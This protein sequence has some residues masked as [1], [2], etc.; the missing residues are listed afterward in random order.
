MPRV[1]EIVLPFRARPYQKRFIRAMEGGTKYAILNYHRQS[2]KDLGFTGGWL[3]PEALRTIG[4]YW[5]CFPGTKE[6][7][8]D[9]WTKVDNYGNPML[10]YYI[11]YDLM[12]GGKPH[13]TNH[14]FR[15]LNPYHPSKPGSLISLIAMDT[16]DPE[17]FRGP[18]LKGV[19]YSEYSRYKSGRAFANLQP[20]IR[21][22]ENDGWQAIMTTPYG[23]NHYYDM[24]QINKDN[25]DWFVQ[26]LTIED[27]GVWGNPETFIA[28][29]LRRGEAW[30]HLQQ[31]YY[32][33]FNAYIR[34]VPFAEE[35]EYLTKEGRLTSVPWDPMK[36]VHTAWDVG[37]DG[38][39]IWFIQTHGLGYKFIDFMFDEKINFEYYAEQIRRKPYVYGTHLAPFDL[40]QY[41][42]FAGVTK[43]ESARELGIDFTVQEKYKK[44]DSIA[45]AKRLLRQSWF[46]AERCKDGLHAMRE[47]HYKW[48]GERRVLSKD[49]VHD[50]SS[51]AC[52]ALMVA[53]VGGGDLDDG[54]A[55][56]YDRYEDAQG[57]QYDYEFDVF[58]A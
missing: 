38:T 31:E 8:R 10:G 35:Y 47:Y 6:I 12:W 39:A 7:R 46:D 56:L 21:A 20:A 19:G 32:C 43:I 48:D 18:T 26:T 24:F 58:E 23:H 3:I 2:G 57:A 13:E 1:Q 42:Y 33:S 49:P 53:G 27:T 29:E 50:W 55:A 28:S 15:L 4:N 40:E 36:L 22:P 11:P 17:D 41:E 52:D 44:D 37:R 45:A 25:P 30:D 9:F 14:E 5:Y 51:H 16:V 54:V 34:G